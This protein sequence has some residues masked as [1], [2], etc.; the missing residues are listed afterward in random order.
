MKPDHKEGEKIETETRNKETRKTD[1]R[2]KE[3]KCSIQMNQIF[4]LIC[5]LHY[6][7]L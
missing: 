2:L 4:I 5:S 1:N 3:N 6:L 7:L